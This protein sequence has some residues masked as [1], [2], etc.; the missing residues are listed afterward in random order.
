MQFFIPAMLLADGY[1]GQ[2]KFQ[3]PTGMTRLLSTWTP[4]SDKIARLTNRQLWQQEPE[5]V[6]FGFSYAARTIVEEFAKWFARP[7][8]EVMQEMYA[9]YKAYYKQDNPDLSHVEALHTLGYLPLNVLHLPEGTVTRTGVVH[10]TIFNTHD[11]FAWLTNY[12]E[13]EL[14]NLMWGSQTMA[15]IARNYRKL[16]DHWADLT[17]N[18]RSFVPFQCHDFSM[19]GM[20]GGS[21]MAMVYNIG[22][23]LFF[24][25][26]DTIPAL[27]A[28]EQLYTGFDMSQYGTVP[29][30]EHS[31]M[32]AGGSSTEF[33]TYD[34]LLTIYP[35]GI[36]S[37]VSDT[38]DFWNV[39]TDILPRLKGKIMARNG[40]LVIR[41]DS[42][43]PV[44]II[45]GD[46]NAEPGSP[47]FKG[48]VELLAEVFGTTTNS[49]G[50]EELDSHIGLIYGDSITMPRA[51]QIFVRLEAKGFASNN[52]VLGI[53]SYTYQ[54]NTRD[55]WGFAMKA[56]GATINGVE[57]ALFKDPKTDDGTKKSFKGYC[58]TVFDRF[59]DVN[60]AAN[61][62]RTVDGLSFA[63]ATSTAAND[64]AFVLYD[65][66]KAFAPNSL[67]YGQPDWHIV[68]RNAAA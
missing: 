14:S 1:K 45:C 8:V 42:G 49:K 11:D 23:L 56:T 43:D 27:F 38:W 34:R 20:M 3:F 2:H 5:V 51:E 6:F 33:E 12:V 63:A 41:P 19:R 10:F 39:L 66:Q 61:C 59:A 31:V 37:I 54:C 46:P 67:T 47:A 40:K 4:R 35:E 13:T 17:C 18:D 26:T 62:Y 44:D 29:A 48:A 57:C 60:N 28:A 50:Y 9:F 53:G 68:Q 55:T 15:T 36:I 7:N 32:C 65:F 58:K 22:H 24:N 21:E 52:V 25:G 30:T 16:C 64:D